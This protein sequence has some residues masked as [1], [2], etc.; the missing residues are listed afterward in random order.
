MQYSEHSITLLAVV[1]AVVILETDDSYC[2]FSGSKLHFRVPGVFFGFVI[3]RIW[4]YQRSGISGQ[5]GGRC[6]GSVTFAYSHT[7]IGNHARDV[8]FGTNVTLD[9]LLNDT[10]RQE[11]PDHKT[12]W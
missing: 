12:K 1:I 5:F 8:A 2:F 9:K 3:W 11:M 4:V 10:L 6:H 7:C